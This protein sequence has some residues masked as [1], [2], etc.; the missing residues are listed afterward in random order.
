MATF[1]NLV[2]PIQPFCFMRRQEHLLDSFIQKKEAM[3]IQ[4]V[5]VCMPEEDIF[6]VITWLL[7]RNWVMAYLI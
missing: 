2:S 4:Q 5:L 3:A 1:L 7:L 6:L